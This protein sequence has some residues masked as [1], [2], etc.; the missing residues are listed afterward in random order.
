MPNGSKHTVDRFGFREMNPVPVVIHMK[1]LCGVR[2]KVHTKDDLS[3]TR[4]GNR[5]RDLLSSNIAA[6]ANMQSKQRRQRNES[7][8]GYG[9][10]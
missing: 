2:R 6:G 4:R 5:R 9:Q 7:T 1:V 3:W 8:D 10:K